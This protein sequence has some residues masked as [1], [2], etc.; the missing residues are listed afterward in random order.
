MQ[1]ILWLAQNFRSDIQGEGGG[2]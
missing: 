2:A 1:N